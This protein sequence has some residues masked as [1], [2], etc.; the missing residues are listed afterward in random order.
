MLPAQQK[1]SFHVL[2]TRQQ[3]SKTLQT[4]E[5]NIKMS[6]KEMGREIRNFISLAEVCAGLCRF[7]P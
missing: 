6:L 7:V 2:S 4:G 3:K 1:I 5:D